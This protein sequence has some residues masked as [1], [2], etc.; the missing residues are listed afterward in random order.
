MEGFFV[1]IASGLENDWPGELQGVE[2][3]V[4]EHL[5]DVLC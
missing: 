2:K 3:L 1:P 4:A 5:N